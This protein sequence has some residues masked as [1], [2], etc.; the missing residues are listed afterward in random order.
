M[1]SFLRFLAFWALI[2][3]FSEIINKLKGGGIKND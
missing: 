3:A 2:V 1:I